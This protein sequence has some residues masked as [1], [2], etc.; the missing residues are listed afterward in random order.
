MRLA[1]IT[2]QDFLR[3]RQG[4][5]L[6]GVLENPELPFDIL[7]DFFNCSD[8]QRRNPEMRGLM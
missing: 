4:V 3:D 8:H 6:S 7:L 1:H 2:R 5:T